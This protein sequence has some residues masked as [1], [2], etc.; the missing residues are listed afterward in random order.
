VPFL[1]ILGCAIALPV[2][3]YNNNDGGATMFWRAVI[4]PETSLGLFSGSLM[5]ADIARNGSTVLLSDLQQQQ[6]TS[7]SNFWEVEAGERIK[8]GRRK[9]HLSNCLRCVKFKFRINSDKP[10]INQ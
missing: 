9:G 6:I 3:K 8:V 4:T 7:S 10:Y 1:Q 5:I 2:P